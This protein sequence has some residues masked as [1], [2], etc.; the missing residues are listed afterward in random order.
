[1]RPLAGALVFVLVAGCTGTAED[2]TTTTVERVAADPIPP[3]ASDRLLDEISL[4]PLALVASSLR[5]LEFV[6]PLQVGILDDEDYARRVTELTAPPLDV[7]PDRDSAWLQ[8]LGALPAGVNEP[9]ARSRFLAT[10]VAFY[11][12]D[13]SRVLVRAGAGIDP[14]VESVVVHEM[15]R[16]LQAQNFGSTRRAPLDGDRAYVHAAIRDGDARRITQQFIG[17]LSTQDEFAYEDGRLAAAED[18]T[19]I[20][21]STPAFVL[22]GL[23][24]PA[25]D[26]SQFLRGLTNAEVDQYLADLSEPA[27]AAP[28]SEELLITNAG[29]EPL[30]VTLARPDVDGYEALPRE[31][32]L[33]VGVLRMLLWRVI[34]PD[35]LEAALVGWG[36]DDHTVLVN[37][38]HVIFAYAYRGEGAEDA[39]ELAAAF[40]VL[41]DT[42][43]PD[44]AYAS[45]R[46]NGDSVLVLAASDPAVSERLDE[47]Y[48]GFGEEVFLVELG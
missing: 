21:G 30:P 28:S 31:S 29:L 2:T 18:A 23:Q 13:A 35:S 33:G 43:L 25:E 37:A 22:D 24:L 44:A 7:D 10:T 15:V 45:V 47:L 48:A 36:G 17:S 32:S 6:T 16:A 42:R 40:R 27:L 14:Y 34:D 20:R 12:E 1:M 5:Q 26:G 8:L 38:D 9:S 41:F 46:V 3:A 4:E 19:A 39:R 11:D